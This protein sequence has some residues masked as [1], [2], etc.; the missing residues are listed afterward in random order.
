MKVYETTAKF[1]GVSG[2]IDE[3]IRLIEEIKSNDAEQTTNVCDEIII[4]AVES[5][6]GKNLSPKKQNIEKL[7]NLI[8]DARKRLD[9]LFRTVG[10]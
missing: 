6:T 7:I 10:N 4:S 1:L 3:I 2:R 5:F 9:L 8:S